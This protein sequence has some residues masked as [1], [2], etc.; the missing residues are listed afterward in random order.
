MEAH[1]LANQTLDPIPN[2]CVS[3]FLRDRE[4]EPTSGIG[5]GPAARDGEE[6]TTMVLATLGLDGDIVGALSQPHLFR[7]PER[8]SHHDLLLRGRHRDPLAALGTTTTKHFATT[9]GL[10]AR[11]ETMGALA[12]LVM[13]LKSTLRHGN[14]QTLGR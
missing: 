9:A 4:S 11:T 3:Y 8:S 13:G 6:V 10:L 12:A 2:D 14:L 5:L 7:D 1:P